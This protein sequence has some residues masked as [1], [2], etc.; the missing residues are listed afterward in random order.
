M[1]PQHRAER[2]SPVRLLGLGMGASIAA[3]SLVLRATPPAQ[4]GPTALLAADR[5]GN[6]VLA[7]DAELCVLGEVPCPAPRRALTTPEGGAWVVCSS[8]GRGPSADRLVRLAP[9]LSEMCAFEFARLHDLCLLGSGALLALEESERGAG[10]V[11]RIE[12]GARRP[13]FSLPLARRV[14]CLG[15]HVLIG[16]AGGEVVLVEAR[17]PPVVL[18]WRS[19]GS[20]PVALAP[21]PRAGT[22]WALV[23]GAETRLH[24]LQVRPGEEERLATRWSCSAGHGAA[25]LAPVEGEERIWVADPGRSSLRL[26]GPGGVVEIELEGLPARAAGAALVATERGLLLAAPGALLEIEPA[27]WGARSAR[28]LRVQGGFDDLADLARF[29][30][31]VAGR[32]APRRAGSSRRRPRPGPARAAGSRA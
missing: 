22:F 9:S 24:L 15:D 19:L 7:L 8:A 3:L 20:S 30:A 29:R 13:W 23:G 25:E 28:L 1:E 12:G 32:A 10:I 16:C 27:P 21:G 17:D 2:A 4:P 18:A 31:S 11:W 14:A 5:G 26:H 6:R